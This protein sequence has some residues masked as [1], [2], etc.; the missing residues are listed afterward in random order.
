M[1][2]IS[3]IG[4]DGK[5]NVFCF[6]GNTGSIGHTSI[7]VG[8]AVTATNRRVLHGAVFWLGLAGARNVGSSAV[9]WLIAEGACGTLWETA[10][11]TSL[12]AGYFGTGNT[13]IGARTGVT[14]VASREGIAFL[15]GLSIVGAGKAGTLVFDGNTCK[16]SHTVVAVC[17][18]IA[19]TDGI[20]LLGA[21]LWDRF[22][23]TALIA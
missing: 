17:F 21:V 1:R 23:S 14:S 3:E 18:V 15:I 9:L 22:T 8:F 4:S 12:S 13:S 19:A 7:A 6:D 11:T 10:T 5:T 2:R 20:V 16:M